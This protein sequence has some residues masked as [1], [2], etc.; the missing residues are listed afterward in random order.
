[1]SKRKRKQIEV[2]DLVIWGGTGDPWAVV[3]IYAE[4][5]PVM[6]KGVQFADI[7]EITSDVMVEGAP[8][9]RMVKMTP[10][11]VKAWQDRLSGR[12][13]E[14]PP[15]VEGQC[16]WPTCTKQAIWR[17]K[18][19]WM[20]APGSPEGDVCEYHHCWERIPVQQCTARIS[21]DGR[22][23]VEC[24]MDQ[25]HA[26]GHANFERNIVWIEDH[27]TQAPDIPTKRG[28]KP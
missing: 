1:M 9:D 18:D 8:L 26:G 16:S 4:E 21:F 20:V 7:R 17:R 14:L 11:E 23:R 10:E 27:R 3:R 15:Q 25:G 6:T 13:V 28:F 19:G 24:S 5:R 2:G 12:W 22:E